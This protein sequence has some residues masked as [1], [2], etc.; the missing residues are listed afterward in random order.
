MKNSFIGIFLRTLI[1]RMLSLKYYNSDKSLPDDYPK[2]VIYMADGSEI[3]GGLSSRLRSIVSVYKL[4]KE[5]NIRFKIN[6]TSPF[7]LNEYLLPNSY[8]WYISPN[9]INYNPKYAKPCFIAALYSRN[10]DDRIFWAKHFLKEQYKQIHIHSD[11]FFAEKD[12]AFLFRELFKL[13]GELEAL[14]NYHVKILGGGGGYISVAFR[15]LQLLG[16]FK[17]YGSLP[18]LPDHEKKILINNC[19]SHLKEIYSENDCDKAFVTSDSVSF[20]EEAKHLPF[21]YVIPGGI[22]HVDVCRTPGEDINL[23]LFLDH[24]VLSH[25]K[26]VYL[27]IEGKMFNS[28]FSHTPTLLNNIP[29]IVKRY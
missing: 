8:D 7:N 25:S 21:V 15:F 2:T 4:C 17:E 19:I 12:Y 6:F 10:H 14:I 11:I 9:E 3:C 22:G 27:V 5:L 13:S 24:F 18:V 23:K 1:K 26:K 16:D 29:F 20:L 28:S